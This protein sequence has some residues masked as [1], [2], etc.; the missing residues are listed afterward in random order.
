MDPRPSESSSPLILESSS[1]KDPPAPDSPMTANLDPGP[2]PLVDHLPS[3]PTGLHRSTCD[4]RMTIRMQD[5]IA[6]QPPWK[7][8][9]HGIRAPGTADQ[10]QSQ[11]PD[12]VGP[13]ASAAHNSESNSESQALADSDLELS[14]FI[15]T[16]VNPMG[17]FWCYTVLPST[18][19]NQY[20]TIHHVADASTFV[21]EGALM[22]TNNPLTEFGPQ[23]VNV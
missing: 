4:C 11:A 19:P 17:L 9:C 6:Q 23:T 15:E 10:S 3:E 22:H 7:C 5:S 2:Q 20:I 18:D 16:E 14:Y 13:L 21:R 8:R 1:P 12:P